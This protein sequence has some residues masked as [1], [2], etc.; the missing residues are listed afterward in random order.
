MS[1]GQE[2]RGYK[3]KLKYHMTYLERYALRILSYKET[4]GLRLVELTNR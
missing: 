2:T 4:L 3:S 1:S